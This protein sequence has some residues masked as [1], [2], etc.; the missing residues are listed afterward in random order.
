MYQ[1]RADD[2]RT[3]ARM[4]IKIRFQ[5]RPNDP[6]S[7]DPIA[8]P[9]M[10]SGEVTRLVSQNRLELLH[11]QCL[12]Q[13]QTEG[14]V[15]AVQTEY[16]ESRHL[17]NAGVELG[18][19]Q[20]LMNRSRLQ[21]RSKRVQ[22][23]EKLR[24]I[25][26]RHHHSARWRGTYPQRSRHGKPEHSNDDGKFG[27]EISDPMHAIASGHSECGEHENEKQQVR[28]S[29]AGQPEYTPAIAGRPIASHAFHP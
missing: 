21:A 19:H 11:A 18:C 29:Q 14:E 4:A 5:F 1:E 8:R 26:P 20:H 9:C 3:P 17:S 27:A 10:T 6:Q 15:V 12:H 13:G 2:A 24:G 7:V 28:I 16:S 23:T 22:Q 25:H